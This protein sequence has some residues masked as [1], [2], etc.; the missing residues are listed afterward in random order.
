M[1]TLS[2]SFGGLA[3]IVGVASILFIGVSTPQPA[4]ACS[5]LGPFSNLTFSEL[6]LVNP[7][8]VDQT[9]ID[10]LTAAEEAEWP[11]E[12]TMEHWGYFSGD[13]GDDYNSL[14]LDLEVN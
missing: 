8:D 4:G 10:E 2:I 13:V 5:C 7:P 12:A 11:V 14:G 6:R 9:E 1:K 3:T